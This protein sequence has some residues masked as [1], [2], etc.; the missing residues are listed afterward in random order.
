MGWR[1][2]FNWL[3]GVDGNNGLFWKF[4]FP[5]VLYHVLFPFIRASLLSLS[6]YVYIYILFYFDI[7][8]FDFTFLKRNK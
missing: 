6:L 3:R 7:Y 4:Y 8:F 2:M 5:L 1:C